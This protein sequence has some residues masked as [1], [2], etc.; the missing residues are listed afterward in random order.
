MIELSAAERMQATCA[1]VDRAEIS[2]A[3]ALM[4]EV[5]ERTAVIVSETNF[6]SRSIRR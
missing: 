3:D 1:G 2:R 6:C 5:N 4:L